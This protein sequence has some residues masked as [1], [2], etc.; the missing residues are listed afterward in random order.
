[1]TTG[2][3][4]ENRWVEGKALRFQMVLQMVVVLSSY[5][6]QKEFKDCGVS[7]IIL[8]A[9]E[10]THKEKYYFLKQISLCHPG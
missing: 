3:D 8:V 10:G 5:G 1:M 6:N 2:S 9:L 7:W 4:R